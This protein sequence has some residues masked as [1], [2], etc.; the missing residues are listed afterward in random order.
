MFARDYKREGKVPAIM[1][2]PGIPPSQRNDELFKWSFFYIY[3][4]YL[5]HL[6]ETNHTVQFLL[7]RKKNI[8]N[9]L[10]VQWLGFRTSTAEGPGS[11]SGRGIKRSQIVQC[12][13]GRQ[14]RTAIIDNNCKTHPGIYFLLIKFIG[15]QP[16]P[17][18]YIL[19]TAAFELQRQS[20]VVA[21]TET[22]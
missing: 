16:C 13:R 7:K 19:S 4:G 14:G 10:V 6:K 3:N 9:S 20:W 21:A 8:E 1:S 15:K 5:W 17:F 11:I 12:G 18:V 2:L 22:E